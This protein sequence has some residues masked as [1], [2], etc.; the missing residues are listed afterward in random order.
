MWGAYIAMWW[1]TVVYTHDSQGADDGLGPGDGAHVRSV[2][3][4]LD[5][6]EPLY[7]E[8]NDQPD[9]EKAADAAEVDK[10]LT[11]AVLVEHLTT[12][13]YTLNSCSL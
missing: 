9:A 12:R 5:G 13:K 1:Y 4:V 6:D 8:G 3:R 7:R 10:H 11:P 2:E